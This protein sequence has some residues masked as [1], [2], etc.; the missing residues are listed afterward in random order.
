MME[1]PEDLPH[2]EEPPLTEEDARVIWIHV[3]YKAVE[4]FKNGSGGQSS[5]AKKAYQ[6]AKKWIWSGNEEFPSFLFLCEH[7]EL[8]SRGIRKELRGYELSQ[9][10]KER[11]GKQGLLEHERGHEGN[12]RKPRRREQVAGGKA[13]SS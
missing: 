5:Q 3:L 7:L 11:G 6:E 9:R 8:N 4:D 12:S 1:E 10:P 13:K 2:I